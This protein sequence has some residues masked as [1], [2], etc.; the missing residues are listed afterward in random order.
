MSSI[1][2]VFIKFHW[3]DE[4]LKQGY[5]RRLVVLEQEKQEKTAKQNQKD[6]QQLQRQYLQKQKKAPQSSIL[7]GPQLQQQNHPDQIQIVGEKNQH[8]NQAEVWFWYFS[9]R[10]QKTHLMFNFTILYEYLK[11]KNI[12]ISAISRWI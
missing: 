7:Y 10:N 4:K 8:C 3:H 1:W 12:Y 11:R 5:H 2:N 6:Q 9:F